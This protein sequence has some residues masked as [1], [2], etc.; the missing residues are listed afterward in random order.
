ARQYQRARWDPRGERQ[1]PRAGEVAPRACPL[2]SL[3]ERAHEP[4]RASQT[5]PVVPSAAAHADGPRAD[6][7]PSARAYHDEPAG[8]RLPRSGL[9]RDDGGAEVGVALGLPDE[10]RAHLPC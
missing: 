8:D 3:R 5:Y 1:E 7:D 4:I 6:R 9:R 2:W 10:Q